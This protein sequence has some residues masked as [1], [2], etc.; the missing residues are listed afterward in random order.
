MKIPL[1]YGLIAALGLI[2]WIVVVHWFIPNP[3]SNIHTLGAPIFF[4]VLH[5]AVIFLGLK[6]LE[7]EAEIDDAGDNDEQERQDE[8]QFDERRPAF[9]GADV[10]RSYLSHRTASAPTVIGKAYGSRGPLPVFS[11]IS[12]CGCTPAILQNISRPHRFRNIS[13]R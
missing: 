9:R 7:R 10:G 12:G 2:A 1:K 13:P 6:A 8:R 4:N 3:Q 11:V 5:F